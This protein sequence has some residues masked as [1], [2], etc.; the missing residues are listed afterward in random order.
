MYLARS[1]QVTDLAFE[2]VGLYPFDTRML[3]RRKALGYREIVLSKDSLLGPRGLTARGHEFHYS[4]LTD[5]P[6]E[7][8]VVFQV[9]NREGH[10]VQAD[11]FMMHN[12]V[13]GY[14]HLH[15]G[16]NPDIAARFVECCR[17]YSQ[18]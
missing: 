6:K 5:E 7:I 13:A 2:M 14:I 8:P 16:S 17:E 11:G 9:N 12:A 3:P 18:G 1:I 10:H 15:F 4:E